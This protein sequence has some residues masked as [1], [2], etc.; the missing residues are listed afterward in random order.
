MAEIKVDKRDNKPSI[1]PWILGALLL[2]GLVWGAVELL[3][4]DEPELAAAEEP[5]LI[6]EPVANTEFVE[7]DMAPVRDYVM[8]VEENGQTMGL[9]HEYTSEGIQKLAVALT[10][11]AD[12]VAPEDTDIMDRKNVLLEVAREIQTDPLSL[13]H[14]N[15]IKEA[16]VAS[17]DLM[18]AL[19]EFKYP[20]L[21]TQVQEV[22]DVAASI[23]KDVQ[24]L[25]QR[26][27]VKNFFQ[28]SSEAVLA[29]APTE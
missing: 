10:A 23:N 25:D 27:K 8:Y 15:L 21:E 5:M 16:F 13:Q 1:W 26:D 18:D 24:T 14:A 3:E 4:T 11:I 29:L 22:Q 7:F 28:E 12:E 19:Q 9:E 2:V 20:G 6:E 17:A